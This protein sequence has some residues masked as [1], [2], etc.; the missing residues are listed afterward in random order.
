MRM[1]TSQFAFFVQ[2]QPLTV[3]YLRT[4]LH[5]V[6]Q[7][8]LHFHIAPPKAPTWEAQ[9]EAQGECYI[10]GA[11]HMV[12][13]HE[14]CRMLAA[15]GQGSLTLHDH[16][17]A[18][19][20]HIGDTLPTDLT[21]PLDVAQYERMLLC[22]DPT[23]S[24]SGEMLTGN[25]VI[26]Q[27]YSQMGNAYAHWCQVLAEESQ[28]FVAIGYDTNDLESQGYTLNDEFIWAAT[29][30]QTRQFQA[31][32]WSLMWYLDAAFAPIALAQALLARPG[33]SVQSTRNGGLWGQTPQWIQFSQEA[34]AMYEENDA[35][36]PF[37]Q[38]I[39]VGSLDQAQR[40][41]CLEI[42]TQHYER[43]VELAQ[44][45]DFV[46]GEGFSAAGVAHMIEF[47]VNLKLPPIDFLAEQERMLAELARMHE[48]KE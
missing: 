18:L 10:D 15:S 17:L 9:W 38:G 27:P 5:R 13:L 32:S 12:P 37:A 31:P 41:R 24:L 29:L 39:L 23:F 7:H 4:L 48:K 40:E 20:L 8:G 43:A 44:S 28:A 35:A 45:V 42:A 26:L 25:A 6:W 30:L 33:I 22:I 11:F 14:A 16:A 47:A 46:A 2:R 3:E 34:A 1:K 19:A 21:S 36:E